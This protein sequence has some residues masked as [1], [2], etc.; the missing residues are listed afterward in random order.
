MADYATPIATTAA[1][2][3]NTLLNQNDEFTIDPTTLS[4][5]VDPSITNKPP[6]PSVGQLFPRGKT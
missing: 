4:W 1:A 5:I 2:P 6:R 3:T